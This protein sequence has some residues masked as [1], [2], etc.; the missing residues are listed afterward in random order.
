M[1]YFYLILQALIFSFGGLLIKGAGTV[2]SPFILSA[3]RFL[4]GTALLLVIMRIRFGKIHLTLTRRLLIIGGACKALHYVGENFGVMRG[5]SYGGILVW[6]VQT[7]AILLFSVMIYKERFTLRVL[8][9]T[10]FSLLG[11]ALVSWN[12]ADVEVFLSSQAVTLLAFV[13]AGIGAAG[14]TISQKK[15][16]KEMNSTEMNASMFTYG[17][18]VTMVVLVPTGPHIKGTLNLPGVLSI[19]LLGV[20]TCVGFL[21]QAEAIK[22]VP[23]LVATIIQ[24]S[25]VLLTVLWGVLFYGDPITVY[26]LA[27]TCFFLTGI[28]LIN[29]R[30]AK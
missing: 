17:L 15:A 7:I 25:T 21:L 26:V 27:G 20:I 18:L 8:A 28:L 1:G 10:F 23:L 11:V 14:F 4:I 24:S 2:C 19:L 16:L 6:P 9:G 12:G 29:V 5:F 22:T 3:F 30:P 13:V